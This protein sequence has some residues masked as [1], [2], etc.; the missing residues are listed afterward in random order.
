MKIPLGFPLETPKRR[1]VPALSKKKAVKKNQP[2]SGQLVHKEVLH[3]DPNL[4]EGWYRKI[5]QR[6][7]GKTAGGWDVY[8]YK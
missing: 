1:T 7:S 3:V 4:P 5:I 8:I 6:Q 2:K